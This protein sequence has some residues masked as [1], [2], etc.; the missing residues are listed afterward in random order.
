MM[1]IKLKEL[2]GDISKRTIIYILGAVGLLLLLAGTSFDKDKGVPVEDK[3]TE[4]DYCKELE[5]RLEEILPEISGVG[6][7]SVMITA[8]NYGEV[9]FAKDQKNNN[10]ETVVLTMKGGGEDAKIVEEKY[11]KIK[12]VIIVADGG[13]S[14]RVK[15]EI[16]EAICALLGVEPHKIKVFERKLT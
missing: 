7:V 9:E 15:N 5:Q 14:D 16:T 1:K 10:N 13:K 4:N 2:L 12:G 11:P 3:I 6:S 8:E